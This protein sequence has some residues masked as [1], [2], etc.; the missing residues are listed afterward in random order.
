MITKKQLT[1]HNRIL[2][3]LVCLLGVG[4]LVGGAMA[5]SGSAKYAAEG[6]IIVNEV[7][8][9][10]QSSMFSGMLGGSFTSE[11]T[12]L[13][14]SDD[15]Q[16]VNSQ[17]HYGNDEFAGDVWFTGTTSVRNATTVNLVMSSST[18]ATAT[19]LTQADMS[20]YGM[21]SV[22]PGISTLTY[23]L[24]ATSTLTTLIDTAGESKEWIFKNATATAGV[25]ITIA[26]GAGIDLESS[27]T[28]LSITPS[29]TGYLKCFREVSTDV[30]CSI[31]IDTNAD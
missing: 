2:I 30:T 13:T 6:D 27:T 17:F 18:Q 12:N 5:F 7:A 4:A 15:W 22:A 25:D 31:K 26:A 8:P 10:A 19:T 11:P 20:S 24:P 1:I 29:A 9:V 21:F 23:T 14:S 3:G 28:T 16:A